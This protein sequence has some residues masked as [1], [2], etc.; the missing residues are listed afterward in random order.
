MEALGFDKY[1]MEI[2]NREIAKPN[3]MIFNTG[4]TGSGKTTTLYAFLHQVNDAG[5]QNHHHRRPDRISPRRH[6]ADAGH[7]KIIRLPKACAP[8][9]ARIRTSSWSA[10]S[11]MLKSPRPPS[12]FAH[13]SP[14]LLDVAHQRR[15][16]H[17]PAPHR[18][19]R[20]RGYFRRRRDDCDGTTPRAPFVPALP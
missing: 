14:R 15:R 20:E 11:A 17:L 2:F 19:G 7:Q 10:R 13:R 8:R 5:N 1:L 18:H 12:S 3:G 6:R 16:R 4:P 9:C